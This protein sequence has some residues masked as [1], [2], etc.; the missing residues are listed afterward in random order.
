MPVKTKTKAWQDR[1]A[2]LLVKSDW[3][4]AE[5][6]FAQ[7]KKWPETIG[8]SFVAGPWD[9]V[10]WVDGRGHDEVYRRAKWV[11]NLKGVENT[12][13]HFVYKGL[14]NGKWWWEWP[15]GS[16]MFLRAP[17]LNGEMSAMRSWSWASSVASL[18]GDWDYLVW[19]GGETWT[20]VWSNVSDLNRR[21]WRT[22]SLVPIRTWWNRRW[23]SGWLS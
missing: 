22:D 15:V 14:R 19:N 8:V 10:L 5:Q 23:K 3:K 7:A 13:T 21:G 2:Y 20:D 1:S 17:R 16:W 12:S 9:L 11:R 4:A 6:I 18:P